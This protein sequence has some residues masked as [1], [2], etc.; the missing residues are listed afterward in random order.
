MG[1]LAFSKGVHAL[2]TPRMPINI[3]R[4]A[5]DHCS[6]ALRELFVHVATPIDAPG[7][8]DY[9][10][11]DI[12]VSTE[13][14][15]AFGRVPVFSTPSE[16]YVAVQ[17]ALGATQAKSDNVKAGAH[18]AIPWPVEDA[19][20]EGEERYIQVDVTFCDTPQQLQWKLFRHAHGDLWSIIGSLIRPFGLTLSEG[21]LYIRVPEI[22]PHNKNKSRVLLTSDPYEVLSFLGLDASDTY[23]Q[24]SFAS[25]DDMFD[26]IL[27]C[28]LYKTESQI[29]RVPDPSAL[30]EQNAA[31][32]AEDRKR[33]KSRPVY[34]K[35]FET[36][37]RVCHEASVERVKNE[38]FN[39][40][41]GCRYDYFKRRREHLRETSRDKF[42]KN[43]KEELLQH[44]PSPDHRSHVGCLL[45]VLKQIL[46]EG[47][48]THGI[49]PPA[50]IEMEDGILNEDV[51][52][53]FIRKH[54][55]DIAASARKRQLEKMQ[56]HALR[57]EARRLE[58]MA[59]AS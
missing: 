27:S 42:I 49:P 10:D 1:G 32:N 6:A 4:I 30:P 15:G 58:A 8:T 12:F 50:N 2:F 57:K 21:S 54:Q 53:D 55:N 25:V 31:L 5:N 41:P 56:Q 40:F 16:A 59:T 34:G 37:T 39:R 11:I 52:R 46:F 23:W 29:D 51:V 48:V 13:R 33:T 18:Y 19:Q 22:E 35:F 36:Y 44:D 47:D 26:Y 20:Q 28:R 24:S 14:A 38:A 3:Y 17:K 7:K 45:Q 9:G 43:F